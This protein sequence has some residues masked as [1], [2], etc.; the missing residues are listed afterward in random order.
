MGRGRES[1][2]DIVDAAAGRRVRQALLPVCMYALDLG[3]VEGSQEVGGCAGVFERARDVDRG[4]GGGEMGVFGVGV[5][6]YCCHGGFVWFQY[7]L[8][9]ERLSWDDGSVELMLCVETLWLLY[10]QAKLP[11]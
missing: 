1:H 2:D 3:S 10:N 8:M 4:E 9:S 5:V 6:G 11:E 7:E